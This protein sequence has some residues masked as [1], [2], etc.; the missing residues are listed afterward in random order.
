[1]D[2]IDMGND[3]L[4]GHFAHF[5]YWVDWVSISLISPPVLVN[6]MDATPSNTLEHYRYYNVQISATPPCQC[7]SARNVF[8]FISL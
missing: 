5:N 2:W 6:V 3:L 4:A 1:V 8:I 7:W